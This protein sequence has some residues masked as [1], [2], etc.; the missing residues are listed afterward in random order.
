MTHPNPERVRKFPRITFQNHFT[1]KLSRK[2]FTAIVSRTSAFP[3]EMDSLPSIN[4]DD[5]MKL[6]SSLLGN[7]QLDDPTVPCAFLEDLEGLD[8]LL[9]LS[10]KGPIDLDPIVTLPG[11]V[12]QTSAFPSSDGSGLASEEHVDPTYQLDEEEDEEEEEAPKRSRGRKS[13]AAASGPRK[14]PKE[15]IRAKN[16]RAQ[17]RYR[18]KQKAKRDET[19]QV[20]EQATADLERLR[21]ENARLTARNGIM[22]NVLVVREHAAD[23]LEKSRDAEEKMSQPGGMYLSTISSDSKINTRFNRL[24]PSAPSK[25]PPPGTSVNLPY[26]CLEKK[27]ESNGG[28]KNKFSIDD[29]EHEETCPLTRLTRAEMIAVKATT[30]ETVQARYKA[31]AEQLLDALK[32]IEDPRA[33]AHTRSTAEESM[34]NVLW[35]TG[36]MCFEHSIL[37]PTAMQKLLVASVADESGD[38]LGKSARWAE[39]TRSLK[40]SDSQREKMQPLREVFLQRA[41]R[42]AADRKKILATLDMSSSASTEDKYQN[43]ESPPSPAVVPAPAA[44]NGDA[45]VDGNANGED[46]LH[47][48]KD[49]TTNW[50]ALHEKSQAL[51]ANLMEEHLACMELVAKCFG[52]VLTPLQKAK[53]IVSSYPAFPDV[54]AIATAASLEHNALPAPY[55]SIEIAAAGGGAASA[56]AASGKVLVQ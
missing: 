42:I 18:E 22:E 16:R 45:N 38:E 27:S 6:D 5:L 39:I 17:A 3:V 1:H 43:Q 51:E 35:Q 8:E 7:D 49:V 21:L 23:I 40:L 30:H 14:D 55:S 53:A 24:R 11:M 46:S 50:L 10:P 54:F 56:A 47:S 36:C 44:A 4:L 12:P 34:L 25:A 41:G 33:S 13:T 48:L 20:L 37:K 15:R 32:E 9:P 52:G 2:S 31:Y 29:D 28:T 19:S 26:S